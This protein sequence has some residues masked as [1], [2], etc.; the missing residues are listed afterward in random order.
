MSILSTPAPFLKRI[1]KAILPASCYGLLRRAYY[2][3]YFSCDQIS[4]MR[5]SKYNGY[6]LPFGVNLFIY[7]A[8]NSAG[9]V[10]RLLIDALEAGNIP[11]RIIDLNCPEKF[12]A[13]TGERL[14]K[15]NL[16][17]CH[18]ASQISERMKLFAIDLSRHYNVGYWLWELPEL[19]DEYCLG[20][21]IFQEIWSASG[22]CTAALEKKIVIPSLT[23]PLYAAHDRTVFANSRNYFGIDEKPF[24]FMFAYDCD[25]FISR[26]NPQAVVDAFMKAFSPEDEQVGLI[27]K[28]IAAERNKE[29]LCKLQQLLSPYK[30]I[31]YIDKFLTDKEMRTLIKASDAVVSLHRSEGFG[32]LPLEA[33]SLGV[34]V[35]ATAWSGNMEYMTHMNAALVDYKLVP[36]G[37]RYV[38]SAP[39]DG[40]MW[41]E[42]DTDCAAMRMRRL[43]EDEDWRKSLI[44]N[45]QYTTDKLYTQDAVGKIMRDRLDLI[46]LNAVR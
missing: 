22:F 6:D 24:L 16:I 43:V 4:K 20:L 1:A 44:I 37:G 13:D 19:P 35:I 2:N 34:P 23:V 25:S 32:L 46:R 17:A 14:Y 7:Y 39:D 9:S 8:N 41:A 26:K 40:I 15:I 28:L 5:E 12:N 18:A 29:H 11:H 10:A 30:N 42:A 45:G 38:G 3:R 21:N 36:V 27:L 33:M 31:Y